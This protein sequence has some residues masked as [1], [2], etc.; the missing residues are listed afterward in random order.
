MLS[1]TS[2]EG[3]R[4]GLQ[5]AGWMLALSGL[6][7]AQAPSQPT[8][9][10]VALIDTVRSLQ[11]E[12][13]LLRT[14]VEE[15]RS[16]ADA[17]REEI[18]ELRQALEQTQA[19]LRQER[20][21]PAPAAALET[22]SRATAEPEP[23]APEEGV[24]SPGSVEARLAKL[25]EQFQFLTSVVDEQ[26]QTK[27][28]SASKY[29]MR[30]SGIV[31]LN[32]FSN[33]GLSDNLDIPTYA[34]Q[35]S[36]GDPTGSFGASLR[37]SQIG[38]EVFGPRLLGARTG[39]DVQLDFAGGFPNTANGANSGLVRLRTGTFH[40]DWERTSIVAGQDQLFFSPRAPT[41]FASLAVPALSYAGNLWSW[42][43][44]VRVEHRLW[45]SEATEV[46]VQAG[47]LDNL[48]GEPPLYS[49]YRAAQAGEQSREPAYAA[50]MGWQRRFG[51]RLWSVGSS[52]YYSRQNYGYKRK[53]DGW[54]GTLD[55]DLS[56]TRKWALSGA[57]YR[58]RAI[59][60]IGGGL[61]RS[62]IFSDN[63]NLPSA[64]IRG[65]DAIGGWSQL[66]YQAS[67]TLEF[68]LAFG[69]DSTF[70]RDLKAFQNPMAYFDPNLNRNLGSFTN[71]IY[72]PRS[73]LLFSGE[74]RY[75]RSSYLTYAA[76]TTG[77]VNL[78]M[79]IL[80]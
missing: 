35:R 51:E 74:Y 15:V 7:L 59:G 68:N 71:F 48:T 69:Q 52:G 40:V 62:V 10:P 1:S 77:Q 22:A 73:N 11:Q 61:G 27:I 67:P 29:R 26:H 80:F 4:S 32:L 21:A 30:L 24:S 9:E 60:G 38:L 6:T 75:F 34:L 55:W 41:S 46:K 64:R 63:P 43:P 58:G 13:Q 31:L 44:Q 8:H 18:L 53:Q 56:L 47:I 2:S 49:T 20:R 57:F 36:Q 37:Q 76:Q 23:A 39:G 19:E 42:T 14:A 3:F 45:S 78:S 72:R 50:R 5:L 65:L 33:R 70:A 28:E 12:V 25:W 66:K 17:S 79:G 16:Q 54:A